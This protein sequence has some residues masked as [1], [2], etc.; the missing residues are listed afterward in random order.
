MGYTH[1]WYREREIKPESY[2][3]IVQDFR[4]LLAVLERQGV[5]L[6]GGSGEGEPR[7]DTENVC[8]NGTVNCRHPANHELVIP[9]P[10]AKAGGVGTTA[11][12]GHWFAGVEIST[13]CCNGDCSYETFDFPRVTISQPVPAVSYYDLNRKPVY[14][15]KQTVGRIFGCCKTAFRPYDWAVTAFLVTAKHY[16]KGKLIVRSDGESTHW[17]DARLLCQLELGYGME[18]NLDND[19]EERR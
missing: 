6:A 18:F 15:S 8:F 11:I 2:Q 4:R 13:R 17:Q 16:L 9:W 1:Y 10:T 14:S 12:A 19:E 7:L 5:K 3:A